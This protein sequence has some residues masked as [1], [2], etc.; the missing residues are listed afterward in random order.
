MR[1][2]EYKKKYEHCLDRF[3]DVFKDMQKDIERLEYE[4]ETIR[5]RDCEGVVEKFD[6]LLS[7][8]LS[9]EDSDEHEDNAMSMLLNRCRKEHEAIRNY[10]E[11]GE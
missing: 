7:Y 9:F 4:L 2:H 1:P 10:Y 8:I 11:G 3:W 5:K 6:D